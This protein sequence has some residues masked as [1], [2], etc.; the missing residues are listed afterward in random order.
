[1]RRG[2]WGDYLAILEE[3]LNRVMIARQNELDKI[4]LLSKKE[5]LYR[6]V[7]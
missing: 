5:R 7:K 4:V 3:I 2:E 6:A 1:M